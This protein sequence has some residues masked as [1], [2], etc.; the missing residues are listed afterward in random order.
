MTVDILRR[1]ALRGL[2]K[3]QQGAGIK[4]RMDY[5]FT[6]DAEARIHAQYVD[7]FQHMLDELERMS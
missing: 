5:F 7:L 6:D 2:K 1:I 4:D 3:A